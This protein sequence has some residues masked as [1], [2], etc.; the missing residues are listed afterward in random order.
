VALAWTVRHFCCWTRVDRRAVQQNI[1][2]LPVLGRVNPGMATDT[3]G[4]L[5]T[6]HAWHHV[7]RY[8]STTAAGLF[9]ASIRPTYTSVH[10]V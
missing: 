4:G 2:I 1:R 6:V 8:G 7:V 3:D 5:G 9:L 10:V